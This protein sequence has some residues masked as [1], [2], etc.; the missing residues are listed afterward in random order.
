MNTAELVRELCRREK[1]SIAELARRTGQSRQNLYKKLQRDTLTL[2][3]LEAIAKALGVVYE[4]SF[5]LPD[6]KQIRTGNSE[7]GEH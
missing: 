4:Q 5:I 1:V 3:E 7:G 2:G 6:G